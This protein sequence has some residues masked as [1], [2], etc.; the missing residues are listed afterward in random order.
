[1]HPTDGEGLGYN[2]YEDEENVAGLA[3]SLSGA[4]PYQSLRRRNWHVRE[5]DGHIVHE[6]SRR[7]HDE[8]VQTQGI[9]AIGDQPQ[10]SNSFGGGHNDIP[11]EYAHDPELWQVMQLSLMESGGAPASNP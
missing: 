5:R 11:P 7:H 4:E 2:R 10:N 8:D 9:A 3:S 1:M 6:R